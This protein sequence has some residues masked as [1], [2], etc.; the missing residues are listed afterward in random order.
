MFVEEPA[1]L[2]GVRPGGPMRA[3]TF[4]RPGATSV[5]ETANPQ[6]LRTCD[7]NS[8]HAPS[9]GAPGTNC[10]LRE[11]IGMSASGNARAAIGEGEGTEGD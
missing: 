6:A 10:G 7:R 9:P 5:S 4:G 3:T 11:S 1:D 2:N 8:A